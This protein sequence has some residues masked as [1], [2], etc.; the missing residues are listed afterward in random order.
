MILQTAKKTFQFK[1]RLTL[2]ELT[3]RKAHN[4]EEL[5]LHLREVSGSCIFHHTHRFLQQHQVL[6]PEPPNDFAYWI[7][8]KL[9]ETELAERLASLNLVQFPS[10]RSIREKIIE[11]IEEHIKNNPKSK[12][13]FSSERSAFH[14]ISSISFV[15]P[16][17]YTATNLKEFASA[18][19]EITADSIYF[20]MFEARLRLDLGKN[21]FSHWITSSL[22]DED[23][24][25]EI[26]RLDPYTRTTESLREK[27]ISLVISRIS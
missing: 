25:R 17:H 6:S 18:L 9:A 19:R 13:K 22:G 1:T 8:Q 5:L 3:G 2:P 27:I 16:I 7:N 20:H 14:F 23:L 26:S 12:H 24:A 10:V 15:F 4:L 11:V 21:D